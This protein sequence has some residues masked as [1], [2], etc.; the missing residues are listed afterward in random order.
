MANRGWSWL[1]LEWNWP[2]A[3]APPVGGTG[4]RADGWLRNIHVRGTRNKEE[5]KG[6]GAVSDLL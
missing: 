6:A 4:W 5:I 3:L 2:S 1:R